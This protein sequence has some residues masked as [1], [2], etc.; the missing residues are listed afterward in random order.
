MR[1]AHEITEQMD[2]PDNMEESVKWTA[3]EALKHVLGNKVMIKEFGGKEF[4][5]FN[6]WV[7][8]KIDSLEGM[9]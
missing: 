6:N 8:L 7:D 5:D 2:E 1:A 4:E 9:K 3:Y